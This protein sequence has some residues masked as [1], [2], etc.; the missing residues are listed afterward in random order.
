MTDLTQSH[1]SPTTSTNPQSAIR[2]PKSGRALVTGAGGFVGK[3][4]LA[5]LLAHTDWRIYANAHAASV[6]PGNGRVKWVTSDLTSK[7]ETTAMVAEVRPDYVFHLAAQS[8]VQEAFKDPEGTFMTN[9][10]GQLN[11]LD[12]LRESVPHARVLVVCSSEEYGLV[13][14]EDIPID[15]DTPFRPNNPYAVSKIAQDALATQY[16]L[17]YGQQAVRVRPFNHIGP[18]QTEHFV[19][20][21]FAHQVANIEAGIQEPV[22]SVG[23]LEAERDFTDVRDTV[24]AYHLALTQGEAGEVYNVGSGVARKMQWILDTFISLSK[25]A[26]EVRQDP[27]RMRPSDIPLL[28]CDPTKFRKLT[29]WQPEIPIEQTLEDILESWRAKVRQER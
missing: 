14:S 17:S 11:L 26:V 24:R 12:A 21:A 23:N 16:F 29:D 15:E 10:V 19:T 25:I 2:N 7:A 8:H 27:S 18:G 28:V 13:R 20:A 9:V 6:H 5:Y 22:I 4:L 1:A 3:H